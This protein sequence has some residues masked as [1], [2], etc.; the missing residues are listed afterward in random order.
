MHPEQVSD[1]YLK[2]VVEIPSNYELISMRHE[3]Q[4]ISAVKFLVRQTTNILGQIVL[5]SFNV[6]VLFLN[7]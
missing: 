3:F 6:D 4:L 1:L 2:N 7:K 5:K